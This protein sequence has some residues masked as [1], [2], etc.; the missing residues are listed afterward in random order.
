MKY[1]KEEEIE[2]VKF[3]RYRKQPIDGK[4]R[5]YMPLKH[6]AA[7]LNKSIAHVHTICWNLK[8]PKRF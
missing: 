8:K 7:F 3:L 6:I 5:T 2:M 1:P 4:N